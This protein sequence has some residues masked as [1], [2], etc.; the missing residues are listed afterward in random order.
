MSKELF[1]MKLNKT[2]AFVVRKHS[3]KVLGHADNFR[4]CETTPGAHYEVVGGV[5]GVFWG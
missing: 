1:P 2:I 4:H 5:F 3:K